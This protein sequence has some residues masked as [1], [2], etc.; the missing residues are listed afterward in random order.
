MF[1][2]QISVTSNPIEFH[3]ISPVYV[4]HLELPDSSHKHWVSEQ[5][6]HNRTE[7]PLYALGLVYGLMTHR[8]APDAM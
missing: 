6:P 5:H 4:N 2:K 1:P 3:G 7:M 8:K